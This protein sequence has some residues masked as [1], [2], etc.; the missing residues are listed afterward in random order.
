MNRPVTPADTAGAV[1]LPLTAPIALV[2][3]EPTPP[4]QMREML[5]NAGKAL[6]EKFPHQTVEEAA[7]RVM[8]DLARDGSMGAGFDVKDFDWQ[9]ECVVVPE[10]MR[11]AA[12]FNEEGDFVIR[13]ERA[14]NQEEDS[15][16]FIA[17]ANI[18]SFIDRLTDALGI[19]SFGGPEPKP[20]PVRKS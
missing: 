19:P 9:S 16:I 18:D 10:Q 8:A 20:A 2:R 5:I 4:E 3:D 1:E 14:W 17:K 12:Y 11:T 13:Q 15:L 7:D 6:D